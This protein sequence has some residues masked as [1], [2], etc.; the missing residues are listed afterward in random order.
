MDEIDTLLICETQRKAVMFQQEFGLPLE[1][2]QCIGFGRAV[3]GLRVNKI[4]I[5]LPP[6]T[7]T[8]YEKEFLNNVR[9]RLMP[10]GKYLILN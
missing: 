2:F 8:I 10:N 3:A 7:L 5:V 4:L 9:C 1:K 6:R